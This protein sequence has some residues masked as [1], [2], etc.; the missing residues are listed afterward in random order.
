MDV[1]SGDCGTSAVIKRFDSL[2]HASS[3]GGF[4]VGF[5]LVRVTPLEAQKTWQS[6]HLSSSAIVTGVFG[7]RAHLSDQHLGTE[8]DFG[9]QCSGLQNGK[10][11]VR[12]DSEE[13][14]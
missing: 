11:Y 2:H 6:Q 5:K 9:W 7:I 8:P 14:N 1:E 12:S 10:K 3:V 4:T 13:P